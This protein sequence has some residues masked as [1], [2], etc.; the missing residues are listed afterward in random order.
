VQADLGISYTVIG[1]IADGKYGSLR[2]P[3][4]PYM[5]IPLGQGEYVERVNLVVKTTGDP[6]AMVGP[7]SAEVRRQ[8]PNVPAS[9]VLTMPQY[10]QYSVGD[11]KSPTILVSAFGLLATL[12]AMVG[13]YGV[14]SYTVS[15]QTRELGVRLALGATGRGIVKLVL[16]RGLRTTVIGIGFGLVLALAFTRLLAGFLYDVSTLDPL[17]FTAA[18]AT[19]LAVGLVA[20]YRPARFAARVDPLQVLRVE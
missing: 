5:A 1:V 20:S 11:A 16:R 17:V 6:A 14:M 13:L 15:Q 2:E 18:A 8:A 7:L 12:L 9:S 4:E 3:S 19:L 10:L